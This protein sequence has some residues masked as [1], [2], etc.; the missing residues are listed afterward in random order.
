MCSGLCSG[1][2]ATALVFLPTRRSPVYRMCE[3]A[4]TVFSS[5][6]RDGLDPE[7]L[8]SFNESKFKRQIRLN[9]IFTTR[10]EFAESSYT[11]L[12]SKSLSPCKCT[13]VYKVFTIDSLFKYNN[14]P[15]YHRPTTIDRHWNVIFSYK[16][17]YSS[18]YALQSY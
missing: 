2:L 10:S 8:N 1:F 13:L 6:V 11:P 17:S 15:N 7:L 9:L 18:H 4:Q 12:I 5:L 16:P 3:R 14:R